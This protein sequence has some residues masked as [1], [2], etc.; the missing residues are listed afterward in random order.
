MAVGFLHRLGVLG[1]VGIGLGVLV[2]RCIGSR[3]RRGQLAITNSGTFGR[4][5]MSAR[6][7][8]HARHHVEGARVAE[9]LAADVVA[10]VRVRG[11]AG[12]DHARGGRDQQGRDLG[13]QAVAD[14]Q[15]GV[16]AERAVRIGM[17]ELERRRW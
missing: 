1:G 15:Q 16:V 7:A 11:G 3:A 4:P 12:D 2:R 14:G 10:Q 9:D 13:D 6:T 17:P 8:Q 5:G